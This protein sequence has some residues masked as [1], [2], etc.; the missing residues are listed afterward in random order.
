MQNPKKGAGSFDSEFEGV[1]ESRIDGDAKDAGQFNVFRVADLILASRAR[2]PMPFDRRDFFKIS[3]LSGRSRIEYADQVVDVA[4]KALWFA[5]SRIPYRWQPLDAKQSGY[6]CIFNDVFLQASRGR[7][8]IEE[9]PFYQV[10]AKPVL[11]LSDLDYAAIELIF[12]KMQQEI[13][14]EYAYK[15][16]LLRAYLLEMIFLIQKLGPSSG[17]VQSHDAASR[18]AAAFGDLLERQFPIESPQQRLQM[19]TAADYASVLTV[20]V[21][22]L[23]RVLKVRMGHSTTALI[24][25]RIAQESRILLRQTDWN[26]SEIAECL[27][28]ADAAHFSN[29]FRRQTGHAPIQFR[30]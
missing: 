21:N 26:V 6:F 9:L 2:P 23:N 15:Y 24:A 3:L 19:R 11:A 25:S 22:H 7:L 5:S 13:K 4:G 29:F 30:A 27:G 28:F 12:L 14:S 20:H 16:E 1:G 10:G 18:L 8:V 17:L